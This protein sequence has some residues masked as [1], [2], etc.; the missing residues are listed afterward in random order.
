[1]KLWCFLH[2]FQLSPYRY[3]YL[4]EVLQALIRCAEDP[5]LENFLE[6]LPSLCPEGFWWEPL[7]QKSELIRKEEEKHY[8]PDRH[9]FVFY[10]EQNFPKNLL[11]S[12]N[13]PLALSY[14]GELHHFE[15]PCISAVGSREPHEYTR[16]WIQREF[17]EFLKHNS[18]PVVSGGARGIDQLVHRLALL[19]NLPTAVILPTGLAKRYPAL[20]EEQ[21]WVS[22]GVCFI[23][24]LRLGAPISKQNFA[25]RNRLIAYYGALTLILEARAKSGTLITAHHALIESKPVCVVPGHPAL[26]QFA[27]SLQ[28]L[29]EGSFFV[30]NALDLGFYFSGELQQLTGASP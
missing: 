29:T 6:H 14:E 28:L 15:K 18:T 5:S 7:L 30:R 19:M 9:H 24:E 4:S 1:M 11:K 2:A 16:K 20:W 3:L 27:G 13:P 21:D 23:S 12:S 17:Y 10:G 8:R 26:S 22:Q 25:S